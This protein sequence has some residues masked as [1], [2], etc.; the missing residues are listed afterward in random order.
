M[1]SCPENES[2]LQD[3]TPTKP[4][5]WP[6]RRSVAVYIVYAESDDPYAIEAATD[7]KQWLRMRCGLSESAVLLQGSSTNDQTLASDQA[8]VVVV[9]QTKHVLREAFALTNL[10]TAVRRH[11]PI[12]EKTAR[13]LAFTFLH[14]IQTQDRP[15][16]VLLLF[17]QFRSS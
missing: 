2:L 3:L 15:D 12:G 17:S 10:Y 16:S 13:N 7:V 5:A 1:Q 11:V 6:Q 9:I 14:L 4:E 8:D